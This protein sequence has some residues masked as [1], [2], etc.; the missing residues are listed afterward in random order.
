MKKILS[1]A[2]VVGCVAVLSVGGVLYLA[3]G[4]RLITAM[5]EGRSAPILNRVIEGQAL[6]PLAQYLEAADQLFLSMLLVLAFFTVFLGILIAGYECRK[7]AWLT[8]CAA[9]IDAIPDSRLGLWIALAAGLGLYSELMIIRFHSSCFQL[10]AYF[11]NVS[12]LSCFLG[13]GIGYMK[14]PERS[15][16]VPFVLPL[17]GTQMASLYLLRYSPLANFLENPVSEQLAFG[18]GQTS[19]FIGT[20]LAYGFLIMVFV[21]NAFCFIPLGHLVSRVMMRKPMLV[22]YSWNLLGSLGGILIFFLISCM[23]A[24]PTLWFVIAALALMAFLRNDM[25][26]ISLSFLTLVIVLAAL[27]IP[28]RLD[29]YDIY[30]P[31][32][33]LTLTLSKD[34]PPN[35]LASNAYYQRILDLREEAIHGNKEREQWHDYYTLPYHFKPRPGRVLI[36]GSGTGNDVAAALRSGAGE[37]DAV[38]I[39]P[40]ILQFGKNLHPEAPYQAPNVHPIVN[41]ARAFIRH[42]NARYDLIVYGL[43][44]SHTLL[45]NKG[46]IRLDSYVYTVEGF[47]DARKKLKENGIISLTFSIIRSDLGR[48]L[49]LM[50]QDAFDGQAPIVYQAGYD[51]GSTFLSGGGMKNAPS[52]IPATLRD[53]TA[54]YADSTV[55]VDKSTDDWPFLYMAKRKYPRSYVLMIAMLMGISAVCV[56]RLSPGV[57]RSRFSYPCFFLG[58][59]FML[60]ETKGITELALVYGSTWIVISVV[61][62]AI[63]IMAFLSNVLVMRL[64][65]TNLLIAYGLL[66]IS[67]IA[68]WGLTFADLGALSPWAGRALMTTGLTLPLFFSGFAFSAELKKSFSVAA[69]LSSNLLGAM[70]GGFVEYNSM[71]FGFRSLYLFA[72]VM[73]GIAWCGSRR[74]RH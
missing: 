44:D 7:S 33:I 74:V 36:V 31:Y 4:H 2:G 68:G 39:D 19:D 20:I 61:I 24:P 53:V 21:F 22:S 56:F 62:I 58:A 38:E 49:F 51:G 57:S 72:L 15:I 27:T 46:G 18:L 25:L 54:A 47:R 64:R 55:K 11:K 8:R 14:G 66:F 42:T 23:W 52:R 12:L 10:F 34:T 73:Y 26:G 43:L 9:A 30:S 63:L 17:L 71:Y 1:I 48:K 41:D 59:G 50:L 16:S 40:A 13:L 3:Y 35:L 29:S 37:I 28:L 69:A 60:V 32:Q 5:Y 70:F 45:S 65:R 67:L 6:H